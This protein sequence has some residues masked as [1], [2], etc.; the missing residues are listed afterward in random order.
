MIDLSKILNSK[1]GKCTW[2][3]CQ[4]NKHST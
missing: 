1:F 3:T 2:D 4:K